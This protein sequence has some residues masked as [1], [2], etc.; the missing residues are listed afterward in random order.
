MF[1]RLHHGQWFRCERGAS[2]VEFA[3]CLP[4]LISLLM[5][6][7]EFGW[8]Q[9]CLSSVRFS[10]EKAGRHLALHPDA[11]QEVL[12]DIVAGHLQDLADDLTSV[13]LT[14]EARGPTG[15]TAVLTAIYHREIGILGLASFPLDYETSIETPISQFDT[16]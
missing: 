10:L 7:F 13:T 3:I 6:V 8:T 1:A 4:L 16:P 9:H 11:S 12:A 5:G 2:A 14:R 15:E